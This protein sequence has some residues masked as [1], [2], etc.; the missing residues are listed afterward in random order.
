MEHAITQVLFLLLIA[1]LVGLGAHRFRLPYTLALVLAGVGLGLFHFPLLEGVHLTPDLLLAIFL[2]ALLFEAAWHVD[3]RRFVR[4]AQPILLLAVPGVAVALAVTAGVGWALLHAVGVAEFTLGAAFLFAAMIAA[5]DPI[6]VLSLFKT[7]GVNRRLYLIV[8]GESLLND[9]VAVVAFVIVAAVLGVAT[10]HGP[11]PELHGAADIAIYA[12]RTFIWMVGAG[13]AVGAT[14]GLVASVVTRQIDDR[15]VETALSFV[16][17]YG[18]FLL[19]EEIHASGV[20]SCVTA[21]V[22]L[23]SVGA[24]IGMSASTRVAVANFWEFMAFFSNS[25]VFLLVGIELDVGELVGR[26]GLVLLIFL[27]VLAGRAASVYGL[28]PLTRFMQIEPIPKRWSHVLF[29][30]GLRGSLSM[31]LVIGL[32]LDYPARHLLLLL[33]FGVVSISLFLQGLTVK[34]LL[35]RLGLGQPRALAEYDQARVTALGARRA[36]RELD[37]LEE[38]GALSAPQAQKLRE[39][40]GRR[41]DEGEA[42]VA[43]LGGE[44][45]DAVRLHEASLLLLA[46]E[47]EAIRHAAAD[48]VVSGEAADLALALLAERR[49]ELLHSGHEHA[50]AQGEK[51]GEA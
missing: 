5:T 19:A 15:Q 46:V 24:R 4:D 43:R 36:L 33:V 3:L 42:E 51:K 8:E 10:G 26:G 39:D 49:E 25:F 40:Y 11:S 12:L 41:R 50:A 44:A 45:V 32:P 2:P 7:L 34:P 9:G 17:A 31:V 14:L 22:T 30:G 18:S 21:G 29:W 23:G 37:E 28:M 35:R 13:V 27:A 20:L 38:H 47:E 6:S 1:A 48:G 16:L